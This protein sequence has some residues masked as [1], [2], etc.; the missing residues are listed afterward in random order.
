METFEAKKSQLARR[1]GIRTRVRIFCKYLKQRQ[2]AAFASSVGGKQTG[3]NNSKESQSI[4]ETTES[5]A[6][7]STS[8]A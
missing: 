8:I 6:S 5:L 1:N 7:L 4:T 3:R 2:R